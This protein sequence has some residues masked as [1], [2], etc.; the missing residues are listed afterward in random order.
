MVGSQVYFLGSALGLNE[1]PLE[2]ARFWWNFGDGASGE[3]RA[4][5]YIFQIP[6]IYTVGLHVSTGIYAA[7]DYAI[8]K[9]EP[10]LLKIESV[11]SGEE[12]FVKI[13]NPAKSAVDIGG[14]ILEGGT[15]KFVIPAYTKVAP[16]SN[17]SLPNSITKLSSAEV[18]LRYANGK[19]AVV[20]S[21]KEIEPVLNP[22]KT[23]K[24]S[25]PEPAAPRLIEEEKTEV[26]VN[27]ETNVKISN[28][29]VAV[30]SQDPT[31]PLLSGT[32]FFLGALLL[33][34]IAGI[35]VFAARKI[36]S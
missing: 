33:S 36:Y 17:I 34:I 10:N 20:Y 4:Q 19:E 7:S 11:I 35:S 3:G 16:E 31:S 18:I 13:V 28:K 15:K 32:A 30:V 23:Q 21:K 5:L 2:N 27:D 1:E 12:G 9:V 26:T 25:L 22:T 29:E 6:G 8:V 14:W 24:P